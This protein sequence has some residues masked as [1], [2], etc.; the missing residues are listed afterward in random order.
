M[1]SMRTPYKQPQKPKSISRS[2]V[3]ILS[4]GLFLYFGY[5]LVHGDRGY[6]ARKGLDIKLASA[7]Q[8]L[9]Q[10]KE[11]REE[12]ENRVRLMRPESLDLD[13]LD[14]RVR[15][16]LGYMKAEERVV[17]HSRLK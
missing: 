3:T 10:K 8:K 7:A 4:F 13:L 12:L 9:A 5:H 15:V 14:E 17:V 1:G 2:L 16:V 6:F 11:D